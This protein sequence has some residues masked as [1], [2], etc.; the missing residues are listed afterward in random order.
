MQ[1]KWGVAN[2]QLLQIQQLALEVMALLAFN[3]RKGGQEDRRRFVC[4]QFTCR[5]IFTYLCH[6][7]VFTLLFDGVCIEPTLTLRA[8][9]G[10]HVM[11]RHPDA[12]SLTKERVGF[13]WLGEGWGRGGGTI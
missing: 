5:N 8:T 12:D 6:L 7:R 1:A 11:R 4:M 9:P 3:A 2:Y 13:C 10:L